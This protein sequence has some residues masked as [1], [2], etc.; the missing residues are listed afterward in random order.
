MLIRLM[1]LALGLAVGFLTS[2]QYM[3][4]RLD[5][6]VFGAYQLAGVSYQKA[7]MVYGGGNFQEC[8]DKAQMWVDELQDIK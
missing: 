8:H 2:T 7:C 4:K 3:D 1:Y 6:I 5:G